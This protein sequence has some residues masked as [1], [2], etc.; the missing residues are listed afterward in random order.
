MEQWKDI[1]GY[2]SLY[3]ASNEGRI[4]TCEGKT[5][6]NARFS[7]RVWKQRILK[8]KLQTNSYGRTDA[9]VS[10]WKDG[11]SKDHLVAR[12][13]AMA[14]VDGYTQG[15]TVNHIDGNSMN[16]NA[17]NL[18]WLTIGDN[19][20]K[21]FTDGLYSSQKGVALI[22]TG[23]RHD[24]QSMAMAGRFLGRTSGYISGCIK[25]CKNA[26]NING[27]LFEIVVN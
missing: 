27:E 9:R 13:V 12:L 21:G 26:S 17:C 3:Q 22:G 10:L 11:K 14:W 25:K 8:Q 16:N 5:T 24:F 4:R 20:R 19:I 23:E 6:Q 2:E 7:K 15:M 18:E 1:P